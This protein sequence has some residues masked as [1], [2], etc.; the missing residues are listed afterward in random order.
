[1]NPTRKMWICAGVTGVV[2]AG[3]VSVALAAASGRVDTTAQVGQVGGATTPRPGEAPGQIPG[4]VDKN[5]EPTRAPSEIVA[6]DH[7]MNPDPLKVAE[8]WTERRMEQAEPLPMPVLT[9]EAKPTAKPT[10]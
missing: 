9:P 2:L 8:H 5:A 7:N 1:M 4:P 10:K 6:E 3:G